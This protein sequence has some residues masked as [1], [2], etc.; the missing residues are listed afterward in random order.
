MYM[1]PFFISPKTKSLLY[2]WI[3]RKSRVTFDT[4]DTR[5]QFGPIIIDFKQV[6]KN[7]CYKIS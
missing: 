4:Q 7:I 6:C 1:F 5:K 2:L 3:F